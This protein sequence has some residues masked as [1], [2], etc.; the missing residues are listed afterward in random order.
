Q[1]LPKPPEAWTTADWM[2]FRK[3]ATRQVIECDLA[4]SSEVKDKNQFLADYNLKGLWHATDPFVKTVQWSRLGMS[5]RRNVMLD[6]KGNGLIGTVYYVPIYLAKAADLLAS[7]VATGNARAVRWM[8][9]T[10][11]ILAPID[12]KVL[13]E[14]VWDGSPSDLG[15]EIFSS[16]NQTAETWLNS[17][18]G[19][20]RAADPKFKA[21]LIHRHTWPMYGHKFSI[22]FCATPLFEAHSS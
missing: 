6:A 18:G 1:E 21:Y 3:S 5:K 4:L 19:I 10:S 15:M 13:A 12:F 8:H 2:T 14:S 11:V 22:F 7:E 17:S 20:P 16:T 9:L